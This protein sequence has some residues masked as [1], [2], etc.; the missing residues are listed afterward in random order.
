MTTTIKARVYK[1]HPYPDQ[2]P[3]ERHWRAFVT[4]NGVYWFTAGTAQSFPE[5]L[6]LAHLGLA[7]ADRY[8]MDAVHASRASRR[9]ARA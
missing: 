2:D 1:S 9:E 4:R 5:A 3:S 6:Q 8:L 7:K